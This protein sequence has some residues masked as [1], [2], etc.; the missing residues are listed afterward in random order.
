MILY[1]NFKIMN[2]DNISLPNGNKLNLDNL[3]TLLGYQI[4]HKITGRIF[5]CTYRF[6][7]YTKDA[8]KE[9][10]QEVNHIMQQENV[11]NFKISEYQL[12]PIYENEV[13]SGFHLIATSKEWD[14][15]FN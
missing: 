12:V 9:K 5:P 6:E 10:M 8:A 2:F 7:I 15:L 13:H 14:D 4:H 1:V 3:N 11:F